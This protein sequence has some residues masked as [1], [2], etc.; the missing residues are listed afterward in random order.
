MDILSSA[1]RF[2]PRFVYAEID[3]DLEFCTS[4]P[5]QDLEFDNT[6]QPPKT[7]M[8]YLLIR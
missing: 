6:A 8:A 2:D 4:L 3:L 1:V 7:V 5:C